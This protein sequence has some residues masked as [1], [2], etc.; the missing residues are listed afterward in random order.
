MAVTVRDI[1]HINKMQGAVLLAG[2]RGLDK[3]VC[4]I[5]SIEKPFVDHPEYCYEVAKPGDIYISKLYVFEGEIEKLYEE[6]EFQHRTAGSGMITHKEMIPFI[7]SE[8]ITRA[9]NYGIPIIAIDDHLGLTEIIFSITDLIIK[10][11]ITQI[12]V[13]HF[14]YLLKNDLGDEEI[15]HYITNVN[16]SLRDHLQAVFLQS[17]RGIS[18]NLFQ[19]SDQDLLL[20][21]Y[22][23]LLYIA[24]DDDVEQIARR[25]K[26]FVDKARN[27]IG[28][29]NIGVSLLQNKVELVKRAVLEAAAAMVFGMHTNRTISSYD[30]LDSF[31]LLTELRQQ[32][33][34]RHYRDH[35]YGRIA[36]HDRDDRLELA[37]VLELFVTYG[38]DFRWIAQEMYIHETTVRYRLNKLRD[39]LHYQNSNDFFADARTAVYASWILDSDILRS[40]K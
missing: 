6:I 25:R 9:N 29:C 30:E 27:S 37:K 23:G 17:D 20:P 1:L 34:L 10:D 39:C 18:A 38:G 8:I 4:R 2:E 5:A 16:H 3:I 15:R 40:I 22:D 26:Q 11:Q 33:S 12:R 32:N 24:T 13:M 36:S 19:S 28:F 21:I 35:F 14:E 7:D 31:A